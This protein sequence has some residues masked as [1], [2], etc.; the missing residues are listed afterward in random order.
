MKKPADNSALKTASIATA[1]SSTL[2]T[3]PRLRQRRQRVQAAE[4]GMAVLKALSRLG[5]RAALSVLA[6]EVAES[7]AKV[8][9][10]LVSL[11]EEGLVCQDGASQQ[12]YL[13]LEAM[14]IGLAAMRQADPIRLV[15]PS[16]RRLC[17]SLGVTCFV[18]VM[19]NKGATIVRFEEPGLPVSVNARAG[20]VLPLLSSATGRV[21]LGLLDET[22]VRPMAEE[23]LRHVSP[24]MRAKLPATDP[25]DTLRREVQAARCAVVRDTNLTGISSVAAPIFDH[26]KHVRA[27]LTALGAT[28]AFDSSMDG[29]IARAIRHEA[30]VV[31]AQL[32]YQAD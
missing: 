31:S 15:E 28:G 7:P 30:Q 20:S 10:Y 21:F 13:G 24:D 29:V 9:R 3:A 11:M 4:T 12:Y 23:E 26:A 19:G 22:S 16:L 32:G 5:G 6:I 8:H 25:I 27:V 18:A 17:E 1:P 14:L 2:D